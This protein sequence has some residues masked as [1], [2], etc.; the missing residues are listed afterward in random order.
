M[1]YG[2]VQSYGLTK[3]VTAMSGVD[4]MCRPLGYQAFVYWEGRYAGTLSP[5]AMDSRTDSMLSNIR[6]VSRTRIVA[7]FA[8]YKDSDPRCCPSRTSHVTYRVTRDDLPL[9]SPVNIYTGPVGTPVEEADSDASDDTAQLFGRRWMLTEV[10]GVAV[11]T[12]QPYIEFDRQAKRFSGDSGCNRISGGF[13]LDGSSLRLSRIVSTFRACLDADVQQVEANYLKALERTTR[14]RIQDDILSLSAGGAP[15]L[16]FKAEGA[17]PGGADETARVTGTVTY[18]QR[19]AL[20]PGAVIEVKLLD[21]S[22][23]DAPA[24][25][26]AEKAFRSAGR[27]VPIDFSLEYDPSRIDQRRRYSIQVRIIQDDRPRFISTQPYPV[28][29]GGHPN[30]VDVVVRPTGR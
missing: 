4:G 16:T 2:A 12:D 8:R 10:D 23:A 7:E 29:T 14:F 11:R 6:L 26:I 19:I 5:E 3:V 21:V 24:L 28:I 20:T 25:T 27:Q 18:L 15:V 13:E 17:D 30:R 9:V 22:R 1:L